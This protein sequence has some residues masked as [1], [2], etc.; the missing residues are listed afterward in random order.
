MRV[1]NQAYPYL[2][3]FINQGTGQIFT[4]TLPIAVFWTLEEEDLSKI[5]LTLVFPHLILF[6]FSIIKG[7]KGIDIKWKRRT[8]PCLCSNI[9]MDYNLNKSHM[10][11]HKDMPIQTKNTLAVV[12]DKSKHINYQ[13]GTSSSTV[14]N[15]ISRNVNYQLNTR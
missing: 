3:S 14:I 5:L 4:D 2:S 1:K 9:I 8:A 15:D 7:K 10:Q 11:V 6:S 13:L 12:Y